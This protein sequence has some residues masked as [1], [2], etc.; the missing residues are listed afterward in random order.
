MVSDFV[1]KQFSINLR[2]FSSIIYCRRLNIFICCK[3]FLFTFSQ[4]IMCVTRTLT[5][6]GF[7]C[8]LSFEFLPL[9]F[10]VKISLALICQSRSNPIRETCL[11]MSFIEW[12]S[13]KSNLTAKVFPPRNRLGVK[14]LI[15]DRYT[16][17]ILLQWLIT[18]TL[19]KII[20]KIREWV[21]QIQ[22]INN[23]LFTCILSKIYREKEWAS[24]FARFFPTL[25]VNA[26]L[27][28]PVAPFSCTIDA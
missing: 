21:I 28:C 14:D 25:W 19:Y 2:N 18:F 27:R 13:P 23:V 11:F 15:T 12:Q 16:D 4:W 7:S 9:P 3:T 20:A 17:L 5:S 24:A 10:V 26:T 22:L 6:N 1:F 8:S